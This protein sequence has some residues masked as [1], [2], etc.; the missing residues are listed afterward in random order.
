MSHLDW[1][2]LLPSDAT[3]SAMSAEELRRVSNLA[4]G[5]AAT[6]RFGISAIGHLMALTAG[7]NQL[8]QE[9]AVDIGWLLKS[10]GTL[11]ERLTE[12]EN[13]IDEV[14]GLASKAA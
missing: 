7:A 13:R 9:T 14:R 11:A 1:S 4:E 3:L 10:L 2:E 6:I 5:E 12:T 8:S